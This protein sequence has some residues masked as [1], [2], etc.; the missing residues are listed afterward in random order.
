M[1]LTSAESIS[2]AFGGNF[3]PFSLKYKKRGASLLVEEAISERKE[4][5]FNKLK[6]IFERL[7]P[8]FAD[9]YPQY[10]TE[11]VKELLLSDFFKAATGSLLFWSKQRGFLPGIVAVMQTSGDKLNYHVH[12]HLLITS[13]G[14]SLKTDEWVDCSHYPPKP[15]VK[16]FKKLIFRSLRRALAEPEF[17]SPPEYAAT[18][19]SS[20]KEFNKFL[21]SLWQLNWNVDIQKNR[22]YSGSLS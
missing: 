9:N 7:L 11:H 2:C 12:I 21:D 20:K 6:Y 17:V 8:A 22:N 13:G 15:I 19:C 1:S 3:S 10:M 5:P 4:K 18:V 16:S 14:L